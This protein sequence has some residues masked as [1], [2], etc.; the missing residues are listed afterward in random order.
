MIRPLIVKEFKDLMRDPRI[1]V[2]FV[3]SALIMPIM[4]L[5]IAGPIKGAIETVGEQLRVGIVD[6]DEGNE[7]KLFIN[8]LINNNASYN[9]IPVIL[10]R[11]NISHVINVAKEQE[12]EVI[13]ILEKGF[14][15]NILKFS[16]PSVRI[17]NIIREISFFGG[18]VVG[19]SRVVSLIE[20]YVSRRFLAGTNIDP[21]IIKSPIIP[22]YISYL[23]TKNLLLAGR[24]EAVLTSLGFASFFLPLILMIISVTVIQM[25][26]TSMAVENEERT[27]ETL[28]T[29]PLSRIGILT[30]KLL[31]A[32][33]VSMIGSLFNFIGFIAYFYIFSSYMISPIQSIQP[34]EELLG[35]SFDISMITAGP[36]AIYIFLSIVVTLL[37]MSSLGI[38][39]GALSRDVR[40]AS[41]ITGPLSM[42]VFI[43]GYYVAFASSKMMGT[44]L[45]LIF[46]VLP[47]TQPIIMS[48]DLVAA[49]IPIETPI[50]ILGSLI[51]S[52]FLI[53]ITARLFSLETLSNIQRRLSRFKRKKK[54]LIL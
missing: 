54:I 27:L 52:L 48:K 1:W 35:A 8:W 33:S 18:G 50:Y 37:F 36:E 29:F 53:Y 40:I 43:P 21:E 42:A 39:V 28:L 45:R 19:G 12:L 41:T 10:E 2:P 5:V 38:M 44:V 13:I 15:Q 46:Y 31:G 30:A 4:G 9:L 32:F 3:I 24:P 47:F 51:I 25:S 14:T 11:G 26:A 7:S 23:E 20:E 6:F 16:R 49:S 22:K 34:T 17:I